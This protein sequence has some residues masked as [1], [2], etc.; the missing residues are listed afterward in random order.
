M[1]AGL[2]DKSTGTRDLR[3]L[4]GL[5]KAM[6]STAIAAIVSL[7]SMAGLP[8]MIGFIGKELIYEAKFALPDIGNFLLIVGVAT[9]VMM[10]AISLA[11][12]FNLFLGPLKY[13]GEKP[14]PPAL[15]LRIGPL[16]LAAISLIFGL[17]PADVARLLLKPAIMAIHPATSTLKLALWHGFNEV[18]LVSFITVASGVALFCFT[19]RLTPGSHASIMK[20]S[21]SGLQLHLIRA[22]ICF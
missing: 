11:L 5:Y 16:L 20:L 1:V 12:I 9:N 4:G 2:I 13:P 7:L 6:P 17:F 3:Q 10:V 19:A 14:K 22:S 18:L 8:P 21:P 15:A